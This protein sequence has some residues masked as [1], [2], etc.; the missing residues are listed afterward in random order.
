LT[1][2]I[3]IY[4]YMF[5]LVLDLLF[6]QSGETGPAR[7]T[8]ASWSVFL[9]AFVLLTIISGGFVAGLKAGFTFN[10]F[11]LMNGQW[12][13]ENFLYLRPVWRNFFENIATVQFDHRVLAVSLALTVVVFYLRARKRVSAP[14]LRLGLHLLLLAVLL[15]VALG[16][17]T[18]LLVV[19]VPLAAAHQAGAV[20]LLTAMLF[21]THQLRR[22]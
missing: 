16:I 13:P 22:S 7:R 9:L 11:P 1:L 15:Q 20:L 17:T 6:P 3:V 2:A 10:T 21:V 5:W 18:L 8:L 19:P 12:V 4:G 14:R